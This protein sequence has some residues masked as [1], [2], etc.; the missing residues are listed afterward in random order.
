MCGAAGGHRPPLQR[1][2]DLPALAERGY[3]GEG[4]ANVQIAKRTQLPRT[5]ETLRQAQGD[6]LREDG[7]D[8][9]RDGRP[10][11]R[12]IAGKTRTPNYPNILP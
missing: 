10:T 12:G 1:T 4:L 9:N 6:S 8:G 3:R 11:I 7:N 5:T 2:D